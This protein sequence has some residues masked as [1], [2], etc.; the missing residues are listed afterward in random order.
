MAA[1]A[2]W[3][4]EAV[5][6]PQ[7]PPA[8]T[9]LEHLGGLDKLRE[10]IDHFHHAVL[11]DDLL[12]E[13][14]ANGKRAHAAHLLVFLEEVMG[15]RPRYTALHKGVEGLFDAHANLCISEPQRRRF[16]ALMMASA[17]AVGLPEDER[18]RSALHRRIDD[19]SRFSM[20]FSQP[21]VQPLSPWPEVGTYEW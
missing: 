16:V 18:F 12:G 9:M 13:M 10:L 5:A 21:G 4:H 15:G 1:G 3:S 14:F 6:E 11:A 19:G 17:D 20:M 7:A 8:Q 2:L